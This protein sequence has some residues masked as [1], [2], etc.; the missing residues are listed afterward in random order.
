ME[1][2]E[3][4]EGCHNLDSHVEEVKICSQ[5]LNLEERLLLIIHNSRPDATMQYKGNINF[6]IRF[7]IATP[8]NILLHTALAFH[9]NC[10]PEKN[11]WQD[12]LNSIKASLQSGPNKPS[13]A[14]QGKRKKTEGHSPLA[15]QRIDEFIASAE[16]HLTQVCTYL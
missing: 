2:L 16:K 9:S 15:Q 1:E 8:I 13:K 14:N 6:H 12:Q 11:Q 3:N 10:M 4:Q 7:C 5:I